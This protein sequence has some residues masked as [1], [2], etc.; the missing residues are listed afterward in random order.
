MNP[1]EVPSEILNLSVSDRLTLIGKI[2]DSINQ[3]GTLPL[4][5]E[6]RRVLDERLDALNENPN[7]GEPWDQVRSE[8]FGE[9]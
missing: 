9:E 6:H 2:W 1:I 7:E 4:S 8:V 5:E 3:E